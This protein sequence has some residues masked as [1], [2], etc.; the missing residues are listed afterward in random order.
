[1]PYAH[2]F[3]SHDGPFSLGRCSEEVLAGEVE[4]T[5]ERGGSREEEAHDESGLMERYLKKKDSDSDRDGMLLETT[6]PTREGSASGS[7]DVAGRARG[8]TRG[9][10]ASSTRN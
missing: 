7:L 10:A 9:S 6:T 4:V 8:T 2:F 1:M 5:V 3:L